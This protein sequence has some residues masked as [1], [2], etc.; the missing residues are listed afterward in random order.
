MY[1]IIEYNEEGLPKCEICGKYY[2]RVVSHVRQ[3]HDMS[4]KDYKKE[5]GFDNKKGICSEKSANA[6]RIKT[7][8]NYDTVIAQ[9]L[10]VGG[11][12]SRFK[13]GS[14]GRTK[15]KV[16]EQT[17]IRLSEQFNSIK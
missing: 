4:A 3:S 14:E 13:Q 1:G 9:N 15:D 12:K 6:T 2:N 11:K 10:L 7:M 8:S 16:T 17:R 5:Y